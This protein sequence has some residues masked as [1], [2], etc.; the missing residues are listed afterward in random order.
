[1]MSAIDLAKKFED[2]GVA[3]IIYTDIARDGTGTGL[4]LEETA[5]IASAVKIP[6]IASG[7]VGSL[8]DLRALKSLNHQNIQGAIIGRALYDGR[9]DATAALA[10]AGEKKKE[11]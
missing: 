3:A 4:N 7:G 2:A 11:I 5:A 1:S 6:V 9:I 10:L 8:E